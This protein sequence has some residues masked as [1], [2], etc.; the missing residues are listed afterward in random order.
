MGRR[1]GRASRSIETG[2][3]ASQICHLDGFPIAWV[4]NI[5][6]VGAEKSSGVG[7]QLQDG[8]ECLAK[9]S[10]DFTSLRPNISDLPVR[11]L[12]RLLKQG[13]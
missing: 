7:E 13:K 6:I 5:E 2:T 8:H 12:R 1:H 4:M 3:H 11:D 9:R 10:V